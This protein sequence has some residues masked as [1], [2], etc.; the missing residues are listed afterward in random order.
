MPIQRIARPELLERFCSRTH[1]ALPSR[2]VPSRTN[3]PVPAETAASRSRALVPLFPRKMVHP[4]AANGY[5]GGTFEPIAAPFDSCAQG[6]QRPGGKERIFGFRGLR[7]LCG[8][9]ERA[10]IMSARWV[11]DLDPGSRICASIFETGLIALRR[12]FIY[13][14]FQGLS[15]RGDGGSFENRKSQP[16]FDL[17]GPLVQQHLKAGNNPAPGVPA[18]LEN[19]VHRGL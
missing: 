6:L 15:H 5:A 13:S 4:A 12:F 9:F 10:A 11:I 7:Y 18:A 16:P 19:A 1:R 17:S 14:F 3:I 8:A 2:G